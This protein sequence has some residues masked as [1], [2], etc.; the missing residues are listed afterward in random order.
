MYYEDIKRLIDAE[1]DSQKNVLGS[2]SAEDYPS[3]RQSV[4]IIHGLEW[5]RNL[6]AE[7]QKRTAE[8]DED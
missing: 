4:G 5:C 1:I 7:I 8:G 6:V 2:G 3:Y